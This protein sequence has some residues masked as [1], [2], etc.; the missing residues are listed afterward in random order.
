MH[1]LYRNRL[2]KIIK[3]NIHS[4]SL[5]YIYFIFSLVFFF[6]LR[7]CLFD[8]DLL[9]VSKLTHAASIPLFERAF[10]WENWNNIYLRS[11]ASI[12]FQSSKIEKLNCVKGNESI[13]WFIIQF[14][15]FK[16]INVLQ[17]ISLKHYAL[18]NKWL[19]KKYIY[20]LTRRVGIKKCRVV[21]IL[22]MTHPYR[23]WIILNIYTK[24]LWFFFFLYSHKER[25][26]FWIMNIKLY[27]KST[28]QHV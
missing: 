9:F 8:S 1:R 11:V 12:L 20:F 27:A 4:Y 6:Y 10:M 22:C 7:L 3:I 16:T 13:S 23:K 21:S 14:I 18:R 25:F 24:R 28:L 2:Q 17:I 5:L 26:F 15:F 19:V